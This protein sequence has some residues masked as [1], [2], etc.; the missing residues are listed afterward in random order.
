MPKREFL[1]VDDLA[2]AAVFALGTYDGESHLNVGTGTDVTIRELAELIAEIVGW[3]GEL[4][5]DSSKPDGTPRKLL[6]VSKLA[7]LGWTAAVDLHEGLGR[8]YRSFVETA[9]GAGTIQ[10][11]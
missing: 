2:D 4:V 3:S 5:F 8:T 10:P 7:R 1:Y 6:D 9:R 11:A